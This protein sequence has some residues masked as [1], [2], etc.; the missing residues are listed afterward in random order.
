MLERSMG[1]PISDQAPDKRPQSVQRA[2]IC[3]WISAALI[4]LAAVA[5]LVRLLA[6][7]G[8]VGRTV[9]IVFASA[10]ALL[11]FALL[12]LLATKL[13]AGR[14]WARWLYAV[15]YVLV[16][17]TLVVTLLRTPD[18][19]LSLSIMEQGSVI[20]QSVFQTAALVFMFTDTSSR[21]L[22]AKRSQE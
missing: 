16:S 7:P 9:L 21:W 13:G 1:D 6:I 8:G 5:T 17:L 15:F 19:F 20:V 14:S 12:A 11:T 22:R 18:A 10:M 2:V 4:A 3:L